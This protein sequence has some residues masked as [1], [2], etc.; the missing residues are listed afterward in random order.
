LN[1]RV[2]NL[3]FGTDSLQDPRLDPLSHAVEAAWRK[4]IVVVVAVG[5]DGPT[6][7]RVTMPAANPYV[8]AV[9]ASDGYGTPSKTD[10]VV[11]SFQH[12]GQP[13]RHADLVAPGRSVVSLRDPGSYIDVNYPSGL[14][15]GD[16]E[17]RY[18]RGSGTSQSNRG[19]VRRGGPVAPAAAQP[20]PGPGEGVADEYRHADAARRPDRPRSG[21]AQ[22][23]GGGQCADPGRGAALPG[24]H[25]DRIARAGARHGPRRRSGER[26]G[27][28]RRAGHHGQPWKALTWAAASTAGTAWTGGTW[29]GRDLE[30]C[31][32][33][34]HLV[35]CP[36]V[37][38]RC[39]TGCNWTGR[40]WSG[41]TWS[42]AVWTGRTWSGRTW[43]GRTWSGATWG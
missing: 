25:R 39:W 23:R 43:S 1:I 3:A 11:A 37:E 24:V 33:D 14:V 17:Q 13:D 18:F 41:R 6:S 34:R 21:R 30:R 8:L 12:Q 29:N 19:R 36:D 22:R 31:G 42:S 27:T 38:R 20:D 2:I 40:T 9:G 4:G 7:T 16:A 5:N 10:D 28:D 32:V 26:D 35:G 15:P